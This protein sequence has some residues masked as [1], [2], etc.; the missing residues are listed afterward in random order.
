M[1]CAADKSLG[2]V[3]RLRIDKLP[4]GYGAGAIDLSNV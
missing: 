3:R 2:L 4:G 1:T